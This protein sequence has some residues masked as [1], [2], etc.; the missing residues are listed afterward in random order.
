[1]FKDFKK[2]LKRYIN[3]SIVSVYSLKLMK[4]E[5]KKI[6]SY[7]KIEIVHNRLF[8]IIVNKSNI[9]IMNMIRVMKCKYEE[10]VV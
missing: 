4:T 2:T 6:K 8:D 10:D 1:M 5:L 7:Q 3:E 9:I